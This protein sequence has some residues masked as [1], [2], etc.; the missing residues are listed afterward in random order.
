MFSIMM[1]VASTI[2]PKSRAPT[3]SRFADSPLMVMIRTAK[4]RA[5]GMVA[6][7]IRALRRSPRKA[8]CTR[9]ISSTPNTR[10]CITV[11]V[12]RLIRSLRS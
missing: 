3:D 12:V 7:T 10:L 9:K 2:R 4:Q 5:K 11:W 6:E 1:T 8:H